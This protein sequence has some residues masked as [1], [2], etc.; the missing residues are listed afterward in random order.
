MKLSYKKPNLPIVLG[1][2]MSISLLICSMPLHAQKSKAVLT[3]KDG[4]VKKG[5]GVLVSRDRVKF[6][7]KRKSKPIKYHFKRLETVKITEKKES[8]T[9]TYVPIKNK[10][11]PRVLEVKV[12]GDLSLY[13]LSRTHVGGGHFG[14]VGGAGGFGG[15]GFTP[16]YVYNINNFYVRKTGQKAATHL[17][18]NQLFSKNFKKA[19]ATYFKDCPSL[20]KKIQSRTFKK[21]DLEKIVNY[22]NNKCTQ[23]H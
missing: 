7:T 4:T 21:R 13:E 22:Y 23:N 9:Y 3:F 20:V 16:V 11:K 6:R 1:F 14:G 12:A 5:F 2:L 8:H 19:A 18:S 10:D 17:G 15:G